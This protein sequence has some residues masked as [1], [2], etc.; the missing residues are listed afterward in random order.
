VTPSGSAGAGE[1]MKPV[2]FLDIDGVLNRAHS[3][4]RYATR[5]H[6]TQRGHIDRECLVVLNRAIKQSGAE[7]VLSSSWRLFQGADRRVG[8]LL[9]KLGVK[10]VCVGRTPHLGG[11]MRG[12]EIAAWLRSHGWRRFAIVDDDAD[13]RHLSRWLVKTKFQSGLLPSHGAKLSHLL[14]SR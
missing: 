8:R 10:G 4:R 14:E 1:F 9:R 3:W 6:C 2:I 7:I 11:E 12:D 5:E 13:M